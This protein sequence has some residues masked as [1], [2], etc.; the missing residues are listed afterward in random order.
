MA[1]AHPPVSEREANLLDE[2]MIATMRQAALDGDTTEIV[3]L[4]DQLIAEGVTSRSRGNVLGNVWLH[5]ALYYGLSATSP[6]MLFG[7]DLVEQGWCTDA[8]M[9]D[10]VAERLFVLGTSTGALPDWLYDWMVETGCD[11][12]LRHYSYGHIRRVPEDAF[13]L[14]ARTSPAAHSL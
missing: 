2:Q 11:R 10:G 13:D 8:D 3:A 6:F 12:F 14:L 7:F 4:V 1:R 9:E 5:T